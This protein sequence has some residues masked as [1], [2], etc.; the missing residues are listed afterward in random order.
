MRLNILWNRI[1]WRRIVNHICCICLFLVI[2]CTSALAASPQALIETSV[3]TYSETGFAVDVMVKFDDMSLYNDQVYLSYHIV[4]ENGEEILFENQRIPVNLEAPFMTMYV[5]CAGLEELAG[6][7]SAI[8]QFDL[9]D[10]KN[11][12]WFSQ[13]TDISF[14]S[15]SVV[16]DRAWLGTSASNDKNNPVETSIDTA[17]SVLPAAFNLAV[18]VLLLV[19]IYRVMEENDKKKKD[20]R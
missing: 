1:S 2:C 4:D 7:D 10:Q 8:I 14:Q 12:Y 15:T 6:R 9:V 5:D 17:L 16:F 20:I 13:K 18:W 11:I 3:M 19:L